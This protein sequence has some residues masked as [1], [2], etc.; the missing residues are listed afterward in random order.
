MADWKKIILSGSDAT[1]ASVTA[2]V[3]VNIGTSVT[4]GT[5]ADTSTGEVGDRVV[6]VDSAGNLRSLAQG[7][8]AGNDTTYAAGDGL[9]LGGAGSLTFSVA[10]G[11]ITH[12]ALLG[13]YENEHV[14]WAATTASNIHTDNYTDTT[15][16]GGTGVTF[17]GN[18][19]NLDAAQTHVTSVGVLQGGSIVQGFGNI[20]TTGFVSASAVSASHLY[21][22]GG[23]NGS[24]DATL[25]GGVTVTGGITASEV[26][27]TGSLTVDGDLT[28]NGATFQDISS[29]II[30]GSTTWGDADGTSNHYFSGSVTASGEVS[31]S[32]F[33]GDG[34][35]LTGILGSGIST[36]ELIDGAGIQTSGDLSNYDGTA[37]RTYFVKTTG[38]SI[39]VN[40]DGVRIKPS[41]SG[42]SNGI[43]SVHIQNEAVTD[44]KISP[45]A[46]RGQHLDPTFISGFDA[47]GAGYLSN[48][49]RF[50]I[51]DTGTGLKHTTLADIVEHVS[52]SIS[53]TTEVGTVTGVTMVSNVQGIDIAVSGD[54]AVP[55]IT[56]SGNIEINDDNFPASGVTTATA[57]S[58]ANGGTGQ[59]TAPAAAD[60]L[61]N[62]ALGSLT[63][64]GADDTIT[65]AGDLVVNGL[66]TSI[67]STDLE[68]T[69]KF[70]LIGSGSSTGD[71]G[72]QFGEAASKGN[73]LVWEDNY[74]GSDGRFGVNR[75]NTSAE[76]DSGGTLDLDCEYHFSTVFAGTPEA[77]A[78]AKQNHN[79][80]IRLDGSGNA[81][82]WVE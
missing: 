70:I 39:D 16:I 6:T 26:T 78:T 69:D 59:I 7:S 82:I 67:T 28:F 36:S 31:A 14:N 27:I 64:G 35:G 2:S 79:G 63:F 73:M 15:Y 23:I 30:T 80:N 56:L 11:Q 12:S 44:A 24:S 8:V 40:N 13:Y 60:A 65:I 66:L 38:G 42:L 48:T 46:I 74:S 37:N 55:I 41:D 43:S 22:N 19:I 51:S 21:I 61:L 3:G 29:G 1:L 34:S 25:N 72:I 75:N 18:T 49:D 81:Y 57:L 68:I 47:L 54:S 9:T 20:Y 53:A 77:A 62:T 10:P 58:I 5:A 52:S 17:D 50:L 76:W 4:A 32:T 71:I 45:G 33:V